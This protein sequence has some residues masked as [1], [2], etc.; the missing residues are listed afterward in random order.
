MNRSKGFSRAGKA[1][2]PVRNLQFRCL[3]LR[4]FPEDVAF[5]ARIHAHFALAQKMALAH[6]DPAFQASSPKTSKA[7]P[8]T[9]GPFFIRDS[10][11]EDGP[12]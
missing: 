5:P 10:G 9:V 6:I 8:A 7:R 12:A 4:I 11:G 3:I 1:A 2:S